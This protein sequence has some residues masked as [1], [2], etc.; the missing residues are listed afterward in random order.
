MRVDQLTHSLTTVT[1]RLA[2]AIHERRRARPRLSQASSWIPKP[3]FGTT[4]LEEAALAL[5]RRL[6]LHALLI[7]R[8]SASSRFLLR[9]RLRRLI[10]GLG[11]AAAW[12]RGVGDDVEIVGDGLHGGGSSFC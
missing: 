12:C 8:R 7:R 3:S 10:R 6:D 11:L 2:P 1:A 5:L 4:D 9:V